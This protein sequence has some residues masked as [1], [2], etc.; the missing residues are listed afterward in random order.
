MRDVRARNGSDTLANR[1]VGWRVL[2]PVTRQ[3]ERTIAQAERPWC[4][5]FQQTGLGERGR[6]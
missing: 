4:R 3:A 6:A 5:A 1:S 2:S